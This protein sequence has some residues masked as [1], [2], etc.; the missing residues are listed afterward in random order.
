MP[1]NIEQELLDLESTPT[2]TSTRR[3][4]TKRNM[5]DGEN[6]PESL[7]D[8]IV[9]ILAAAGSP[10]SFTITLSK[11]NP[12]NNGWP[13]ITKF[14]NVTADN[15]PDADSIGKKYGSGK[16]QIFLRWKDSSKTKGW[17]LE[18][19]TFELHAEYDKYLKKDD[20]HKSS[21]LDS[22]KE[23]AAILTPL[24]AMNKPSGNGDMVA[25]IQSMNQQSQQSMQMMMQQS[26]AQQALMMQ[27]MQQSSQQ[28]MQMMAQM[29]QVFGTMLSAP[30]AE[31]PL[32]KLIPIIIQN[33]MD[34]KVSKSDLVDEMRQM[35]SLTKE[36][37]GSN[38][39][40]KE[41]S[42]VM[43]VAQMVMQFLPMLMDK[44][45]DAIKVKAMINADAK[46]RAVLA[47]PQQMN[48]IGQ[49]LANQLSPE[50]MRTVSEKTG[51]PLPVSENVEQPKT[52]TEIEI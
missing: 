16:Y 28:N 38:S 45:V 4:P 3:T 5:T 46:A 40:E 18:S 6:D 11:F 2:T 24:M 47:N 50:Q 43:Q 8:Q 29:M 51:I 36:L 23:A 21:G 31:S 27:Q 26:Q 14:Q 52:E 41:E 49:V 9:S 13:Q 48:R 15:V 32:D 1:S 42:T 39:E 30:K 35:V 17:A 19:R 34:N 12:E 20:E 22:F 44:A 25:L 7:K 37:G 10:D 33:S